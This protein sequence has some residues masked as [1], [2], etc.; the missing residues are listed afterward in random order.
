MTHKPN[1]IDHN[2]LVI[3]MSSSMSPWK[4]TTIQVV[5][6]H[7]NHLGQRTETMGFYESRFTVYTFN[8]ETA[9]KVPPI[10]YD[11]DVVRLLKSQRSIADFYEPSGSTALVK[12]TL[13][14][15]ED[16]QKVYTPYGD[17][18]FLLWIV[19]D[20]EE[21]SSGPGGH[22][23]HATIAQIQKLNT[24]IEQLS[25]DWVI[26]CLVPNA[27]AKREAQRFGFPAQNIE[28][29]NPSNEG[30][31]EVGEKIRKA[32]DVYMDARQAGTARSLYSGGRGIFQLDTTNLTAMN[33]S[34][35]LV[36]VD[37]RIYNSFF[38]TDKEQ[39]SSFVA[40]STNKPYRAGS[41]YYEHVK[42]EKV[43]PD[44]PLIIRDRKTGN[45]YTGQT[46]QQVR[47]MVGLPD[48]EVTV[49]PKHHPDYDL[50]FRSTS[51]NRNL[52]PGQEIIVFK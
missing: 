11:M 50:F 30:I 18:A 49:N 48:Y 27:N 29:W 28:I 33:V 38:V 42:S 35:N 9:P 39:I 10:Y 26:A 14:A 34:R 43:R 5:D 6:N 51:F 4:K 3:D 40:R 17:H 8:H 19:T 47:D 12:A 32:T 1:I 22:G 24:T 21:N 25:N 41:A 46:V 36:L 2:A 20:G 16:L 37:G 45:V 44:V 31:I 13:Q 23:H 15:I 52:V 7:V